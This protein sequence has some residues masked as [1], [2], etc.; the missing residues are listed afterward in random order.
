MGMQLPARESPAEQVRALMSRK[1][2]IEAEIDAQASILR[3]NNVT[4][5]SPLVDAEGFPRD[6]IDVWQ[7][8]HARVRIIELRNDLRDV[9]DSIANA[10]QGVYDPKLAAEK[11]QEVSSPSRLLPF[12]KVNGVAP[13]SPAATAGLLREDL[14]LSFGSLTKASFS[15]NTLGPLATFVASQENKQV[16]VK[17]LRASDEI[18]TLTFVPKS[19]WGG[20]GLL[21]CHIVPHSA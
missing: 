5:Q 19:G 6:D 8:R 9:M 10:L 15:S 11:E 13:N 18:V 21:G 20:R 14:I 16:P 17:V 7:V 3:T 2:A 4:M 1:D 12:A